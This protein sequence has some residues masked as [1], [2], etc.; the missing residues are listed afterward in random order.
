[1]AFG[2]PNISYIG[3]PFSVPCASHAGLG[4]REARKIDSPM[5]LE[6]YKGLS[7]SDRR[8]RFCATVG[9]S[10]LERHVAQLFDRDVMVLT[11]HDGPLWGGPFHKAGPVRALAELV[12]GGEEAELGLSVD[13]IL[14][15]RGVGTYLVQTAAWLLAPQGVKTIR[16]YTL[17]GN[18]AM[19]ALARRS[20]AKVVSESG[21]VE[22]DFDVDAL[23][24]AYVRRRMSSEMFKPVTSLVWPARK[25]LGLFQAA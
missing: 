8:Q 24:R 18:G 19:I 23:Y 21:E 20:G 15:R 3:Y 14:R 7:D 6:H 9:G 16:A 4:F 25:Q 11:A 1:M 13:T 2:Y 22:I 17:Q 5:I 10:V 12:I